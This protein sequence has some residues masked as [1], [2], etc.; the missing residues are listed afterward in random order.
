MQSKYIKMLS[1]DQ[2][3]CR[4]CGYERSPNAGPSDDLKYF[5]Q[6]PYHP[7]CHEEVEQLI[8]TF[9]EN[10]VPRENAIEVFKRLGINL[11]LLSVNG[12]SAKNLT[13]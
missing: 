2:R 5:K 4:A 1:D 8:K 11:E 7:S 6:G 10:G 9:N 13:N 3:I 12:V